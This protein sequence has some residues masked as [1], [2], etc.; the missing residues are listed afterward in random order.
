M[1]FMQ[2][3]YGKIG[4]GEHCCWYTLWIIMEP[5]TR[6]VARQPRQ[7]PCNIVEVF[8]MI[9]LWVREG[10]GHWKNP[11]VVFTNPKLSC[12]T[13]LVQCELQATPMVTAWWGYFRWNFHEPR[14]QN[15]IWITDPTSFLFDAVVCRSKTEHAPGIFP[16]PLILRPFAT[17]PDGPFRDGRLTYRTWWVSIAMSRFMLTE[18]LHLGDGDHDLTATEPWKPLLIREIIPS[19]G[20][21]SG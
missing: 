20:L 2:L 18:T 12:K 9:S 14:I 5:Q 4:G 17:W 15:S 3:I 7:D 10:A 16:Y 21:N 6:R 11:D 19:H 1:Q 13:R 8:S